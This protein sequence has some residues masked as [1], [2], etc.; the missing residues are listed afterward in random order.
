MSINELKK[1][2]SS[3]EIAN[4]K[5]NS[6]PSTAKNII[7][8]AK[9]EGWVCRKRSGRGGGV[10]Y[11]LASLPQEIQDEIRERFAL[12]A[13]P[14]AKVNVP[15]VK[16]HSLESLTQKQ[17]DIADARM[18]LVAVVSDLEQSM[19]RKNA[20]DYLCQQAKHNAVSTEMMELINTANAKTSRHRTLSSRTLMGWVL[21]YHK[22]KTP[23]ERLVTLAP[24]VRQAR[25]AE[26]LGWLLDFMAIY[27]NTNG[28]CVKEAYDLYAAHFCEA[29]ADQ[30]LRL[31]TLP[32]LSTVRRGL[33][34]LPLNVREIGRK[35][36]ASLRALNTYVKRDWSKLKAN[37]VW[38]GDGH[39][40][41]MK[42]AHPEHG[43]PFI[44]ELTLV[45]DAPSRFIVGWSVSLSENAK[46]VADA[47]R[48]GVERHGIP[49][50]YYSDNGGGEKNWQ[51]DGDITGIFPRLG[52]NHQTGIPGNP[53]GRGIIERINKTLGL[54]IARQF[55]TYHGTGADSDTVRKVSTAVVSLEK[56]QRQGKTLLTD[57]Q[58]WAKGKLPSWQAFID[59]VEAG[60]EWYNNHHKHSEIGCTPAQ[61]RRELL[62]EEEILQVSAIEARDM[63]RPQVKRKAQRGW[64][65]VFNNDY[66][67]PDLI[68]VDGQEVLVGI[69]IHDAN[70]V[71]VRN[72]DGS[73]ICVAE[74][75]GNK[76]A[77]FPETLVEK[78]RKERANRRMQLKQ[79]QIS[80]IQ[81]ELN[82]TITIE[83]HNTD[84]LS[85]FNNI[86]LQQ[87][88]KIPMLPSEL[89]YQRKKAMGE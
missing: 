30:P 46:A 5:L 37:D 87:A 84:L 73:L 49:A 10:E 12:T 85:G 6:A 32:S 29:F 2:Y 53:Q 78:S 17:R 64:L 7:E 31:K 71:V 23:A 61:K 42:V 39:A 55:E 83:H 79:E 63:F 13:Q 14:K 88:E 38:V 28:I 68:N 74:W 82:P 26:E 57:K 20:V 24:A 4:L 66:F 56:A 45:M 62:V 77:A 59:A 48:H 50:I 1:Y 34:K 18:A 36:G 89:E 16:N 58:K 60:V 3:T 47:I 22:C 80:E 43:R 75:N 52:I 81:A 86:K 76:R 69:D 70:F 9:R 19:T 40:M 41:K 35:T 15:A 33:A 27:R 65:Q 21:D 54:R 11:A 51:L 67:H 25:A 72:K 8:K 44:P